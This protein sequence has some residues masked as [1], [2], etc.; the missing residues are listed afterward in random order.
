MYT[1]TFCVYKIPGHAGFFEHGVFPRVQNSGTSSDLVHAP[2]HNTA[3]LFTISVWAAIGDLLP[4]RN[5]IL[6]RPL[7]QSPTVAESCYMPRFC[8]QASPLGHKPTP[9]CRCLGFC[10]PLRPNPRTCTHLVTHDNKMQEHAKTLPL[11]RTKSD[12]L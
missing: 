11:L 8:V 4:G 1:A 5:R 12:A 2:G 6:A 3:W 9:Q 10:T 7:Y